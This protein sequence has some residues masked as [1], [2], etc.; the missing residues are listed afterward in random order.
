MLKN[1]IKIS[2]LLIFVIITPIIL[3]GCKSKPKTDLEEIIKR[4]KIIFGVKNDTK[5]FGFEENGNLIGIDIDIARYIT[6]S[7]LGDGNKAEFKIVDSANRLV[8]LSSGDVDMVIASMSITPQRKTV[9]N[10]SIPYHLA[11]QTILVRKESDIKSLTDLKNKKIVVVFGS[12]AEKNLRMVAPGAT[13]VGTKSYTTAFEML[14]SNQV[15]GMA[16][17][18]TILNA[19]A[20]DGRYRILNKK[21][22]I[23]PYAI[24]FRKSE[25]SETLQE[26]VDYILDEMKRNGQLKQIE[27]KWIK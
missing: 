11:G 25:R 12:T 26:R 19:F 6:K 5:P 20:Q 3:T 1:L 17:D 13:I 23:E 4:D 18:D 7:I 21:Y 16:S 2:V 10:F 24:G 22:T 15:E 9:I 8:T 27:Q 14:K